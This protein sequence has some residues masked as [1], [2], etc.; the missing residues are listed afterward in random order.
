MPS[1]LELSPE[2]RLPGKAGLVAAAV[3][4]GSLGVMHSASLTLL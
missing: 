4:T 1:Q 3:A 2:Q